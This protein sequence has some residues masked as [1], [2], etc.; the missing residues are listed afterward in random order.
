MQAA[1]MH[2]S[3]TAAQ[4]LIKKSKLVLLAYV[5]PPA[6]LRRSAISFLTAA[7]ATTEAR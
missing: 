1:L 6:M 7:D 5:V 2:G 4:T 3:S